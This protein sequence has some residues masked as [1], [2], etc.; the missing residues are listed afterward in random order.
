MTTYPSSPRRYARCG[1]LAAI[2][3]A[4]LPVAA[5]AQVTAEEFNDRVNEAV[6]GVTIFT[7]Q[8][9]ASS[10]VFSFDSDR[11]GES[12]RNLDILKLPFSHTF[13]EEGDEIRPEF[14]AV[15]GS[16]KSTYSPA[17]QVPGETE[18]FSRL[19]ANT[20]GV[21]GGVLWKAWKELRITPLFELA[22]THLKRRYDYN[23]SFS[24]ANLLPFDR[25]AFNTSVD[26]LTYSPSIEADYT[27]R[28]GETTYVPKLR[29]AHLFNDSTSSKSS[30]IDIDSDSGLLQTFL[31]VNTPLGYNVEGFNL[32][33]HPFIVRTDVFGAAKDAN[34]P[35]Y[36]H[37][38]GAD[39]TFDRGGDRLIKGFSVGGS[40][41]FGEDFDGYRLGFGAD[42]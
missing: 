26:V 35:N 3:A 19:S 29:Y 12:D 22:W 4:A 25:E 9:T 8:D 13:G 28:D 23:N 10:G 30:L 36:F 37:E 32:G 34:G 14:R 7:T 24:Q 6:N 21:S 1:L 41:I 17:S 39:V 16:F 11:E 18:D 5:I 40:Y 42:F 33:L 38:I 20:V 31:D 27:F 2:V 15:I